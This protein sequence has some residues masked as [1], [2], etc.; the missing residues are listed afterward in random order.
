MSQFKHALAARDAHIIT[1]RLA[2]GLLLMIIVALWYGWQNAPRHLT[3]HNPPDLRAGST[4][5]WWEVPPG[6]VYAFAF[7]IFQQVNRWPTDGDQDYP[8]NLA[9][10]KAY[11]TPA[12][13]TQLA[14]DYRLRR[15]AGELRDRVRG[16]YEIPG[17]GFHH[18][19][20]EVLDRDRWTVTL[21][22]TVDE[23]YRA[24]PVKRALARYPLSVVRYDVDAEKNPWGL[25]LDC[26]AKPPQ[27]LEATTASE[28]K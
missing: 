6:N 20:V 3:I 26:F 23:Y 10:L 4:R 19:R 25:A 28:E 13:Q 12:C 16:V 9:A 1:L 14:L 15:D 27:K 11:L 21:D 7:Y 22:L 5:P 18:K 17:R 8:R 2:L 24:E